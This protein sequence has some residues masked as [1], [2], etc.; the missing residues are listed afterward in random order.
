MV[1]WYESYMVRKWL[2]AKFYPT[3]H[4]IKLWTNVPL[5]T[6][7]DI[8]VIED[9]KIERPACTFLYENKKYIYYNPCRSKIDLILALGHELGHVGLGH[10]TS[11]KIL[12]SDTFATSGIEKDAGIVGFLF[13]HPSLEL[14]KLDL[15]GRLDIEEVYKYHKNINGSDLLEDDFMRLCMSRLRIYKG[16][17]RTWSRQGM[18]RI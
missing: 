15:E 5:F 14:Y 10:V 9:G 13:W 6:Q 3:Q 8:V 1:S 17:R 2:I 7:R 12:Y 18:G 11:D 16:L 4:I